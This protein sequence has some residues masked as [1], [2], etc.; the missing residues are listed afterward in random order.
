MTIDS[1]TNTYE[2]LMMIGSRSRRVKAWNERQ[3]YANWPRSES[4][5]T[6]SDDEDM[7]V[8]IA[9]ELAGR[10]DAGRKT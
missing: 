5:Y 6:N 10:I 8:D 7:L 4:D 1:D 2:L 3:R 9:E